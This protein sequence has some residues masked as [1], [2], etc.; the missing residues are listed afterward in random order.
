[1][2]TPDTSQLRTYYIHWLENELACERGYRDRTY[3]EL[4]HA[5]F[6]T[7]FK[8]ANHPPFVSMDDN[9]LA[10]GMELRKEFAEQHAAPRDAMMAL[11]PCSFVEV[12][13]GLSR[14]LAFVAGGSQHKWAWQLLVNLGLDRMWDHLSRPKTRQTLDIL[15]TVITRS[16]GPDGVG[17]FFPLAFPDRDQRKV[18][19]W[20]QLNAYV[21]ELH[22]EH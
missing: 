6:H 8:W 20:Y 1:M 9:R 22:P 16:Y 5:M 7:E 4:T 19:L 10:D 18:E 13:I 3:L 2:S 12:L 15:Q 11:G 14:R 21:E 17:G